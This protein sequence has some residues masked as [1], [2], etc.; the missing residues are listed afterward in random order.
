[1]IKGLER[2]KENPERNSKRSE[3]LIRKKEEGKPGHKKTA[4]KLALSII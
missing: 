4:P 1:M 2:N 3:S